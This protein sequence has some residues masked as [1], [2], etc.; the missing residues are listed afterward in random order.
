M[1]AKVSDTITVYLDESNPSAEVVIEE[2][3]MLRG[4]VDIPVYYGQVSGKHGA[5]LY[6]IIP[7]VD[8]RTYTLRY[9]RSATVQENALE[10]IRYIAVGIYNRDLSR[11]VDHNV[12][13]LFDVDVKR[14]IAR[15][16]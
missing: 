3:S 16:R 13:H 10:G 9:K 11:M 6:A 15:L 8:Y 12:I 5:R 1:T 2:V 4:V 14:I 7:T